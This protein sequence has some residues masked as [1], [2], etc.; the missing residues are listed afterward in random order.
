MRFNPRKILSLVRLPI[1]P[2]RQEDVW[3][4][5]LF[6]SSAENWMRETRNKIL[7]NQAQ[8]IGPAATQFNEK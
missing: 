8:T 3:L 5:P 4:Q 7:A 6:G 2:H 1:S